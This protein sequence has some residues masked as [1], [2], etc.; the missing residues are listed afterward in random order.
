MKKVIFI[1]ILL[2]NCIPVKGQ[3][4]AEVFANNQNVSHEIWLGGALTDSTQLGFFNYTRFRLDYESS[5]A[6]EFL[7]Y[8]TINYELMNGFGLFGGAYV[9]DN[10]FYPVVGMSY[11]VQTE[12]WLV[13]AFPSLEFRDDPNVELFLFFQFH[14]KISKELRL[15]SQLI[16]NSNFDFDQHNFSEQ[17]LRVGLDY[18]SFQFGIGLDSSQVEVQNG[19]VPNTTTTDFNIN[20]GVFLRK[21]F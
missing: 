7:S 13:N 4:I 11:F 19:A 16:I 12:N 17:N 2:I 14:P 3:N 10:E 1:F 5:E 6:N 20:L 9:L 8:S 21:E 15:F 18:R